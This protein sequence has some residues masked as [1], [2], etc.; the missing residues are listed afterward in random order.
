MTTTATA[1]ATTARISLIVLYTEQMNACRDFYAA[2][3]LDF[4]P[5]QHGAGPQHHAAVLADGTVFEIYPAAPG[6]LTGAV[7]LGIAVQGA[8]APAGLK[9]G[10]QV[11][12]DPDGRAVDIEVL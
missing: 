3:G 5:E 9:P 8:Q 2:L 12:R 11:L 10:H 7:R 1:A 6:R 4:V